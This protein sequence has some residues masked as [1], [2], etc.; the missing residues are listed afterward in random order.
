MTIAQI[1]YENEKHFGYSDD[2]IQQKI[3]KIWSVMDDCIRTGVSS[4]ETTLP[5]RLGL[6]RRAPMLYKRLMRGF[7]PGVASPSHLP[8][9]EEG[10]PAEAIEA[11]EDTDFQLPKPP[12]IKKN[13]AKVVGSFDHPILPMPPVSNSVDRPGLSLKT[14]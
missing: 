9:I 2:D 11:P 6:R 5:G 3:F 1:V 4:K 14:V 13:I 7:Y 12:S 8:R 10:T